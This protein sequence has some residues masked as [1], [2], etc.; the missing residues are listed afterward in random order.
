MKIF[1]NWEFFCFVKATGAGYKVI[2]RIFCFSFILS[3]SLDVPAMAHNYALLPKSVSLICLD[4]RTITWKNPS[5]RHFRYSVITDYGDNGKVLVK[6]N[7]DCFYELTAG[8][9]VGIGK[10]PPNFT[11]DNFLDL[12][13]PFDSLFWQNFYKYLSEICSRHEAG[14]IFHLIEPCEYQIESLMASEVIWIEYTGM[15][16]LR[17]GVLFF[18]GSPLME[19]KE[20]KKW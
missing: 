14:S 16:G 3:F 15:N 19:L 9:D 11:S 12:D 10:S 4:D 17:D 13:K 7:R 2:W 5:L 8:S 20:L 6:Y 1:I 18:M